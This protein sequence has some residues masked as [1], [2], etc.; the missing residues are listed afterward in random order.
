MTPKNPVVLMRDVTKKK[1]KFLTIFAFNFGCS[2]L[3][4]ILELN[5]MWIHATTKCLL[6][7]LCMALHLGHATPNGLVS[8][9]ISIVLC[10]V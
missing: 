7:G 6:E 9:P 4:S 5:R 8:N 2:T 3:Y 10:D 1:P